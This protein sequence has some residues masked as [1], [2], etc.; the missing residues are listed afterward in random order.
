MIWSKH[1]EGKGKI[2]GKYDANEYNL[3]IGKMHEI[4]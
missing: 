4:Q 1:I 2:V 3:K